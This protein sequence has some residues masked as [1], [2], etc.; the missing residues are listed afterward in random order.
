MQEKYLIANRIGV[1]VV[2]ALVVKRDAVIILAGEAGT[3][4]Q[5]THWRARSTRQ[6]GVA[7]DRGEGSRSSGEVVV[8]DGLK[9]RGHTT[10]TMVRKVSIVSTNTV[11]SIVSVS[12]AGRVER[13]VGY[14]GRRAVNTREVSFFGPGGLPVDGLHAV[15]KVGRGLELPFANDSPTDEY[16]KNRTSNTGNDDDGGLGHFCGGRIRSGTCAAGSCGW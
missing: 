5:F 2:C 14:G 10:V 7:A 15:L 16:S 8:R 11:S 9:R 12:M 4:V 3:T 6:I 13:A 1:D